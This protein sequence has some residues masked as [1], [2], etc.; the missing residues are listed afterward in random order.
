M[1]TVCLWLLL[2]ISP[3]WA[4]EVR[5]TVLHTTDLHG[6]VENLARCATLIHQTRASEQNV[7]LV[8]NGDT[9]QGTAVSWLT[10]GEV[11]I[12]LMNALRYDAW[13]LGNHE[14]D[15]GLAKLTNCIAQA[16]MP[17]LAANAVGLARVEP[18]IIREVDGVKV[19]VM[20]LTTP[21]IPNWS[22]PRLIPGLQFAGSVETL[23]RIVP[24]ARKAGAQLFVLV[25]HQGY[26]ERGDDHANQIRAIAERFPEL[27]VIIGGHSHREFHGL[28]IGQSLYTQAGFHGRRLGRV[29]LVF[30]TE[31]RKVVSRRSR[32]LSSEETVGP[33]QA[34]MSLAREDLERAQRYL[35]TPLGEAAE[36][37]SPRGG[38]KRETPIHDLICRAIAAALEQRGV[39]V[40]A[41]VHGLL[42]ARELLAKGPVTIADVWRIVPYENTVGVAQLRP[43]QLREILDENAEKHGKPEFRGIWGIRWRF[44]P[45]A[46]TGKRTLELRRADGAVIGEGEQL[47]VAF[48]SYE[49][50]SGGL[51]WPTLREIADL[52][53]TKLM[54]Y[55][56]GTR[57]ALAELIRRERVLSPRTNGWWEAAEAPRRRTKAL[58]R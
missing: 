57:E 26:K 25:V 13:V 10:G 30:D 8:D 53:G 33:D 19:A 2:L 18:Y 47:A 3:V 54:E 44:D 23:R 6:Q 35:A 50:A 9:I 46:E 22:R 16:A 4:R 29:D 36:D 49:L 15:W 7:L 28:R 17:V 34:L 42:S 37:I 32:T 5:I 43:S 40:D 20:G 55:D 56:I 31:K 14:F 41:V 21:G 58:A 48:N 27:E 51:R 52:P 39:K 11:M 1:R 45:R 38:P 24:A 12:R